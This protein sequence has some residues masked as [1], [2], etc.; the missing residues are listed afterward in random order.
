MSQA[1]ND[2]P[3]SDKRSRPLRLA[4]RALVLTVCVLAAVASAS[5][6]AVARGEGARGHARFAPLANKVPRVKPRTTLPI[7]TVNG[8]TTYQPES[9]AVSA[10]PAGYTAPVSSSAILTSFQQQIIPQNIIGAALTSGTPDVTL[11]LVTDSR[12]NPSTTYR[13]WVIVYHNTA[14]QS[15]GP[16]P[17][18]TTPDCDF[19]GIYNLD[20]SQW[21]EFFQ[22]CPS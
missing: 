3:V 15:Y 21:A 10:A 9:I 18:P 19:V 5:L 11:N 4:R 7:T 14:P 6:W 16:A 13:G 1:M 22:D 12:T 17:V 20:T 8:T 2:Q